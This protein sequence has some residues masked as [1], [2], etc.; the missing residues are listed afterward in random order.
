MPKNTCHN[1][2][3]NGESEALPS[4]VERSAADE[5]ILDCLSAE[6]SPAA[7]FNIRQLQGAWWAQ[8][9]SPTAAFAINGELA[10]F[11]FMCTHC[12]SRSPRQRGSRHRHCQSIIASNLTA[13]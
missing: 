4:E 12:P 2:G 5:G 13:T 8:E 7:K 3:D 11:D 1:S 10:W 6:P 9:P